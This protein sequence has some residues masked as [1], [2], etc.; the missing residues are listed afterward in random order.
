MSLEALKVKSKTPL[1]NKTIITNL[2]KRF[3]PIW[4]GYF[5]LI[6]FQL[7]V[8][9]LSQLETANYLNQSAE[10]FVLISGNKTMTL[11]FVFSIISV[12]AVFSYLYSSRSCGMICAMPIKRETMF[13]SCAVTG[14]LPMILSDIAVVAVSA[15]MGFAQLKYLLLWLGITVMGNILFYGMA[16]LCACLT[17]NIAILPLLYLVLN[18]TGS[19]VQNAF[20]NVFSRFVYGMRQWGGSVLGY[21]TPIRV[22][23]RHL[24]VSEDP[25]GII[26]IAGMGYLAV[27]CVI[28][29]GFAAAA[30]LIFRK[31]QM[32]TA[33]DIVALKSLKPIFKYCMTFGTALVLAA[34]VCNVLPPSVFR[35]TEAAA[36]VLLLMLAGAVLGWY[37]SEMMMQKSFHVFKYN[38][39]GLVFSCLIIGFAITGAEFNLFGYENHVPK[40]EN[41]KYAVVN[42]LNVKERDNI[43]K[44][45][46]LHRGLILSKSENE[47]SRNPNKIISI[48]Y[49]MNN[50]REIAREYTV[51]EHPERFYEKGTTENNYYSVENCPELIK[52]RYSP[53]T[54]VTE[55]TVAFCQIYEAS[56][57]PYESQGEPAQTL[58][59]SP[60]QAAELFNQCI[61]PDMEE[62]LIGCDYPADGELYFQNMS[63]F[64]V[65]IHLKPQNK[66]AGSDPAQEIWDGFFCPIDMSA[67][68]TI[69]WIN[70]NTDLNVKTLR[71]VYGVN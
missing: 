34:L 50:G 51:T 61:L 6:V 68:R 66:D 47:K 24:I 65:E 2:L 41:V 15:I 7:P 14:L 39:K 18:F 12:M 42:F 23:G 20:K 22:L 25:D 54:K 48:S 49:V 8:N 29:I 10:F 13:I 26:R 33:G 28:G 4:A 69:R 40:L 59:L 16:L 1:F 17:G 3:W 37:G 31:R 62:G 71:E 35:G 56:P 45:I 70:E 55:N 67:K 53:A 30:F 19:V 44:V 64:R 11:S 36:I 46:Q 27:Y 60:K 32:E 52:Q 43:E 5:V 57:F 63:N 9:V 38:F 21:L 58:M